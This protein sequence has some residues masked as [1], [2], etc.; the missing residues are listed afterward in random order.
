[1]PLRD[2]MK[3]NSEYSDSGWDRSSLVSGVSEV[4]SLWEGDLSESALIRAMFSNMPKPKNQ[5]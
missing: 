4:K 2:E 1:M 5:F 3:I